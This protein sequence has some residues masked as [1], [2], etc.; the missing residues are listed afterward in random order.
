MILLQSLITLLMMLGSNQAQVESIYHKGIN[1]LNVHIS[2]LDS[3]PDSVAVTSKGGKYL[4]GE[5][6]EYTQYGDFTLL[7]ENVKLDK[8]H[9]VE[10]FKNKKP[11]LTC[12]VNKV[13]KGKDFNVIE[14]KISSQF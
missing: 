5:R 9:V 6:I 4:H 7:I 13:N 11:L 2:A 12:M 8:S 14:Y 3:F 10:L 1:R